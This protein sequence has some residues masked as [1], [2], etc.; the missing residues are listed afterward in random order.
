[1]MTRRVLD[2]DPLSGVTTYFDYT[3]EDQMVITHTQDVDH[4]L[5]QNHA[6]RV[7]EDYS[8]RGIKQDQ[9]HYARIPDA[10]QLEMLQKYGVN[11]M[12]YPIDWKSVLRCIN[13]HYPYLKVTDKT[14][15]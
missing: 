8:R 10:V 7:D 5:D 1:M 12:K 4:V 2:H 13:T 11:M 6:M 14:H 15:A 3:V 9:W